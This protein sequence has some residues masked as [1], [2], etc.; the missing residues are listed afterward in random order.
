MVYRSDFTQACYLE[1][2]VTD[3]TNGSP[4]SGVDVTILNASMVNVSST[5]LLGDYVNGTAAANIYD[6]V[7]SKPGY[8][9]D[10]ISATL[11]S[12]V[13]TIVDAQLNPLTPFNANGLIN[14]SS[15]IGV[16]NAQVVIYNT[17]FTFST[18]TDN[19]GNFNINSMYEGQY[20]VVAGQW[21][22][23]TACTDIY[24]DPNTNLTITLDEGY[25]DD[26]TFDFGW[27]VSGGITQ[28]SDGIWERGNPEGTDRQGVLYNPEDDINN[29]CSENAY[30]TGL[31]AGSAVGDYDV[32][33]FNTI[34]T[35]PVFDLSN[36]GTYY[37]NYYVWFQN[38]FPWGSTPE[39]SLTVS[40]SNGL[41]TVVLQTITANSP[42]LG[43]WHYNSFEL[44]QYITLTADM[45]LSIETA[46]WD[47]LG[48]HWVE[49]GFDKFE[50]TSSPLAS[51]NILSEKKDLI[52][53]IDLLGREVNTIGK[54]PLIYIYSDGTVEKRINLRK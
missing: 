39:D 37:I 8:L 12:G 45:Q 5:N 17:D 6:I 16:P 42:N 10:T 29:D 54:S 4:I 49:A 33:D 34:L 23:V 32:D 36:N 7:F 52:K 41:N 27:T 31:L 3:I 25:Y 30:V 28:S 40:I 48:G 47:G 9:S 14:I 35:S 53:I 13:V 18:T 26:F 43:Q 38:D 1:G 11:T 20:T 2:N 50:I 44:S 21:G 46:D 22:Y 19:N 24:I 15:G 51:I